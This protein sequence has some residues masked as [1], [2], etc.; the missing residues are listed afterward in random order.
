MTDFLI[1]NSRKTVTVTVHFHSSVV[2]VVKLNLLA[3]GLNDEL[4]IKTNK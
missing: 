2:F 4:L 3:S 1:Y